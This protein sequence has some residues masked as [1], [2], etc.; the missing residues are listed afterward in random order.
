[1]AA[2]EIRKTILR[3]RSEQLSADGRRKAALA[4]ITA[5]GER[6]RIGSQVLVAEANAMDFDPGAQL[7]VFDARA[8][9][10]EWSGEDLMVAFPVGAEAGVFSL[11]PGLR[12]RPAAGADG[13]SW[14][15]LS[16]RHCRR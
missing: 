3:L 9:R 15:R 1:M 12:V 6:A 10:I 2:V 8:E 16:T 5:H 7:A 11:C 13:L 4:D 14:I